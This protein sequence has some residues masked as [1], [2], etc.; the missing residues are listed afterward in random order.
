M[1]NT[2]PNPPIVPETISPAIS[3]RHASDHP[4]FSPDH[5]GRLA[6][7]ITLKKTSTLFA[8][9][10]RAV[11]SNIGFTLFIAVSVE[12]QILNSDPIIITNIVAV[13][14]RPNHNSA[15]GTKQMLGNV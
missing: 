13:S 15:K 9:I 10:V 6:G 2:Y 7:R 3:A 1:S 11:F 8:P 12:I 5:S 14:L 4:I